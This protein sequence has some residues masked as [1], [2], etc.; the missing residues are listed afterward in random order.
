MTDYLDKIIH[1]DC[2][3]TMQRLPDGCIDCIITDPPYCSGGV[4]EATRTAAKGQGLRSENISK[5][6][7]FVG[8]N[9][10]TA[11]LVWL[12]RSMAVEGLR[13]L[14]GD[15]SMLVFCDWRMVPNIVP[16]LES[17]GL[18]YQNLLTWNK[19]SMGL[20]NGF[21][22]QGELIIHMTA[23]SPKYYHKGTGNVLT[24]K[25]VSSDDRTHQTEKPLELIEQLVRVV[26]PPGGVILDPFGGSC[27]TAEAAKTTGR[28]FICIE[29]DGNH[30]TTGNARLD[31]IQT[32]LSL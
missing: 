26:C 29:R 4:S 27:T 18:R 15:G 25:R 11:G 16:A 24:C 32:S 30:V 6:G 14:K 22:A 13:L 17:A 20:G 7:W 5:M 1:A 10:G 12:L 19:K 31:T 2:L 9:M 23:G 3:Q 8:D 21:R 28:H